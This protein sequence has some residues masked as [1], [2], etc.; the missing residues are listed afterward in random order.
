M[1]CTSCVSSRPKSDDEE[2]SPPPPTMDK[3]RADEEYR[4][5]SPPP[6]PER[7]SRIQ[8]T[9]VTIVEVPPDS[10]GESSRTLDTE[11]QPISGPSSSTQHLLRPLDIITEETSDVS[12]SENRPPPP[13]P[14]LCFPRPKARFNK[15]K[16]RNFLK[17]LLQG[18]QEP[19]TCVLVDAKIAEACPEEYR[20]VCTTEVVPEEILEV[21][22]I[23][24][25]SNSSSL[26]DLTA[27]DVD[28]LDQ[29]CKDAAERDSSD[30]DGGRDDDD[31]INNNSNAD[32]QQQEHGR[33]DVHDADKNSTPLPLPQDDNGNDTASIVSQGEK[34]P[35]GMAPPNFPLQKESE[36]ALSEEDN[37]G[38]VSETS[39][40]STQPPSAA[41]ASATQNTDDDDADDDD[42]C[43]N[44]EDADDDDDLVGENAENDRTESDRDD[45]DDAGRNSLLAGVDRVRGIETP[46]PPPKQN[47]TEVK[48][49]SDVDDTSTSSIECCVTHPDRQSGKV[50]QSVVSDNMVEQ[51]IE[52]VS[53]RPSAPI[54]LPPPPAAAAA[55]AMRTAQPPPVPVQSQTA[56]TNLGREVHEG[57]PPPS[58]E[59]AQIY[60]G[61]DTG[62][63]DPANADQ[64]SAEDSVDAIVTANESSVLLKILKDQPPPSAAEASVENRPTF[65]EQKLPAAAAEI[66]SHSSAVGTKIERAVKSEQLNY[67]IVQDHRVLR[68]ETIRTTTSSSSNSGAGGASEV[69]LR[70][71]ENRTNESTAGKEPSPEQKA[72][73]VHD[74]RNEISRIKDAELQEEFRKL[75]LEA[76]RIEQ[77]L[78]NMTVIPPSTGPN[79]DNLTYYVSKQNDFAVER[80][81][82]ARPKPPAIINTTNSSNDQL[83]NEWQQRMEE[84]ETR[85]LH[86]II[87]ISKSNEETNNGKEPIALPPP[88]GGGSG[89]AAPDDPDQLGDEFIRKVK[90]R[91]R[92]FTI[93]GGA[94]DSDYDS[95]APN[96]VPGTPL[97]GRKPIPK[98]IEAEFAEF[99]EIRRRQQQEEEQPKPQQQQQ[100]PKAVESHQPRTRPNVNQAQFS[101]PQQQQQQQFQQQQY[102]PPQLVR[103]ESATD[104]ATSS[105]NGENVKVSALIEVHQQKQRELLRQD[106]YKA[107]VGRSAASSVEN[108]SP[109]IETDSAPVSVSAKCQEFE[110]RLQHSASSEATRKP[111]KAP[112][113]ASSLTAISVASS[114]SA[115]NNSGTAS[116]IAPPPPPPSS[117]ALSS[118]KAASTTNRIGSYSDL[119]CSDERDRET[120]VMVTHNADNTSN[121]N[122]TILLTDNNNSRSSFSEAGLLHEIDRALVLAKD[123][124]FTRGVWSPH[125]RSTEILTKAELAERSKDN[126]SRSEP[127]QP[128]WTPR[129]APP[130]PVG[131]RREFRPIGY[132][133]P[134]PQRRNLSSATPTS[135][136]ETPQVSPPWT[137]TPGYDKP[138]EFTSNPPDD[139]SRRQ[140]QNSNSLPTIGTRD[141]SIFGAPTHHHSVRFAAPPASP[142]INTLLKSKEPRKK[143]TT[144]Y[145]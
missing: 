111:I 88:V 76:A 16:S 41:N 93:P 9:L 77:E 104:R 136:A 30:G 20:S 22:I 35:S 140:L 59:N 130:S 96:S 81:A 144:F 110:R 36:E 120:V 108:L 103:A 95:S 47:V 66:H 91:R 114:A 122:N 83:Y 74:L 132:E 118:S 60:S 14:D 1:K 19:T 25:G 94:G 137:N 73:L 43:G 105:D 39:K 68:E 124:L 86:K 121:T 87:K 107:A 106:S 75:E 109:E 71:R 123:F 98:H 7:P 72:A 102:Q 139:S 79:S 135:R 131:E 129:S 5:D 10:E 113:P 92:K 15:A 143:A 37:N 2:A 54:P 69:V 125:N 49:Y 27:N 34:S 145:V 11:N 57:L 141:G 116:I 55:G 70:R 80:P 28:D 50:Q 4:V 21:E 24:L 63:A 33:S 3:S 51:E 23:D 65:S 117:S 67:E 58:R 32:R 100:Q 78:N 101:R 99:A 142:T 138:V 119:E 134:T 26:A 42:D 128:V 12:D 6:I 112:S 40:C 64:N 52:E 29:P 82:P 84:R 45:A 46:S 44:H 89:G 61:S 48:G 62:E 127:L 133:S 17:S 8:P 90:E 56:V 13:K 38:Y 53:R 126:S 31:K 97:A 85:R 115:A 18:K